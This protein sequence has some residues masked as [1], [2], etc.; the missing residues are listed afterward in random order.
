[1]GERFTARIAANIVCPRCDAI[2]F[3]APIVLRWSDGVLVCDI[4]RA[5]YAVPT[6]EVELI[7]EPAKQ[8]RATHKRSS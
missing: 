2:W 8:E 7:G 1:M 5:V 4:C 3:D 6:I